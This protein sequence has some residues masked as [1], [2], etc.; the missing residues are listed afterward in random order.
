MLIFAYQ[1][2]Q[3]TNP[4]VKTNLLKLLYCIAYLK[5]G[6]EPE[7]N[8]GISIELTPY[9]KNGHDHGIEKQRKF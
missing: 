7:L 8:N 1:G 5:L 6:T 2:P 3:S 4:T 9:V